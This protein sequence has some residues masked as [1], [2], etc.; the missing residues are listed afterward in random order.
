MQMIITYALH[1]NRKVLLSWKFKG[2]YDTILFVRASRDD[3]GLRHARI[4]YLKSL[5]NP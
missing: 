3:I 1:R 5:E 4:S 2:Y